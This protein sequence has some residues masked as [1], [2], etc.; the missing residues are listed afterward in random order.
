MKHAWLEATYHWCADIRDAKSQFQ[1]AQSLSCWS[2]NTEDIPNHHTARNLVN[3]TRGTCT[4]KRQGEPDVNQKEGSLELHPTV[5]H[6]G[7][8]SPVM[9]SARPNREELLECG[10]KPFFYKWWI[11]CG[12]FIYIIHT[13]YIILYRCMWNQN[14]WILHNTI[15]P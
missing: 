14:T 2:Q 7:F 4:S 11:Y 8:W 15:P 10:G 13:Y 12:G 1:L 9:S 6:H 5:K 3:L